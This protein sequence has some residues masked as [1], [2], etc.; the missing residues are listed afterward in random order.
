ML[1]SSPGAVAGR[2]RGTPAAAAYDAL[3]LRS[4]PGAVA[5]RST[6]GERPAWP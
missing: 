2:S 3:V 1:R 4:S 5:G 6:T